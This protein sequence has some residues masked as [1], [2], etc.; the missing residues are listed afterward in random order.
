MNNRLNCI[1]QTA[2]IEIVPISVMQ[3]Q[4]RID[5]FLAITNLNGS[6]HPYVTLNISSIIAR[7]GGVLPI[8]GIRGCADYL[9]GF[10]FLEAK[11][12]DMGIFWNLYLWV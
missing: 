6:V 3:E 12:V 8:S 5:V 9:G 4:G 2:V 11:Y 10:F 1:V 7:G